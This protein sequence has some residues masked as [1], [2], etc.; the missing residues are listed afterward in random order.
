VLM[1]DYQLMEKM[2]HFNRGRLKPS[3]DARRYD[4]RDGNEDYRQAGDLY[5]LMNADQ[6]SQSD[7]KLVGTAED[8]A[9]VHS[10]A[11]NKAFLQGVIPDSHGGTVAAPT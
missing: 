7:S 4:Q 2:A 6:K 11:S 10:S 9:A 8:G 1:Q 5:R 3:G